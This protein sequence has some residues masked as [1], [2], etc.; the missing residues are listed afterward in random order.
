MTLAAE[1]W[2]F[3]SYM[4]RWGEEQPVL[5]VPC[6]GIAVWRFPRVHTTIARRE[7]FIESSRDCDISW[8]PLYQLERYKTRKLQKHVNLTP[9]LKDAIVAL[10]Q[11]RDVTQLLDREAFSEYLPTEP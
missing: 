10:V 8:D 7:D 5:Y 1:V 11:A 6:M 9:A 3:V 4:G 2:T